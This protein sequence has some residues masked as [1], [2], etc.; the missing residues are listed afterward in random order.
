[1]I[2]SRV[3]AARSWAIAPSHAVAVLVALPLGAC[4]YMVTWSVRTFE[5]SM[6]LALIATLPLLALVR[7]LWLT[8]RAALLVVAPYLV[9]HATT[10]LSAVLIESGAYMP[11]LDAW[12]SPNGTTA[13]ILLET[14]LL[15][16]TVGAVSGSSR[17]AVEQPPVSRRQG[18]LLLGVAVALLL[19]PML[20]LVRLG[21]PLLLGFDRVAFYQD[22][23]PLHL[24]LIVLLLA[25]APS[26]SLTALVARSG[27]VRW[28]SVAL[29]VALLAVMVLSSEKFYGLVI[30]LYAA[31]LPPMLLR[32]RQALRRIVWAAILLILMSVGLIWYQYA[33]IYQAVDVGQFALDRIAAQAEVPWSIDLATQN[34]KLF[35]GDDFVLDELIANP[36]R[37][38]GMERLMLAIAPRGFVVPFLDTGSRFT[39]GFPAILKYYFSEWGVMLIP[40]FGAV[41]GIIT[42]MIV[43]CFREGNILALWMTIN[44][45]GYIAIFD[46]VMLHGNL[47]Q[48]GYFEL[49]RLAWV[50]LL[51]A[52]LALPLIGKAAH[53]RA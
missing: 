10:A 11:E 6:A 37:L 7:W 35:P 48:L 14:A 17:I 43:H 23:G 53:E 24:R 34:G 8:R 2:D 9:I 44:L 38:Q 3:A 36:E 51:L 47:Y 21:S 12:G 46:Q 18:H 5:A 41:I 26:I 20:N 31:A 29:I 49:T 40:F 50:L 42:R 15:F 28:S 1:M 19:L 22:S 52:F 13:R 39:M 45:F 32:R 33:F 4:A 30:A 27:F 25:A 16:W